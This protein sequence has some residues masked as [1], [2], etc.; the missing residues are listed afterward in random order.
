MDVSFDRF[1]RDIS[2]DRLIAAGPRFRSGRP[3][4][5]RR[6]WVIRPDDLLVLDFE[7]V[8]LRVEK[9]EG[10]APAQLVKQGAGQA[11]LVVRFPP[12]HLVEKAYFTTVPGLPVSTPGATDKEGAK[13]VDPDA[14]KT[15]AAHPGDCLWLV[16]PGLSCAR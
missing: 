10:D 8:N 15:A 14:G 12:Q 13:P 5:D 6:A 1:R 7:L 3:A 2:F 11:Y 9:S 16:A 4:P